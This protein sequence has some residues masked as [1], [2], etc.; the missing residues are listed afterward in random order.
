MSKH[1]LIFDCD[2]VIVDSEC[3]ATDVLLDGI[4][5]A[6]AKID[7]HTA[8][9]RFLGRSDETVLRILRDEFD[10]E[11]TGPEI[12]LMQERLNARLRSEL[13]PTAGVVDALNSIDQRVCVASSSQPERI[14]LSLSATGLLGYFEPHIFSASM[15]ANGKPAPDLFLHAAAAVVAAPEHCIVIEDSPAGIRAAQSAGMAVL[16]YHRGSHAALSNLETT[17]AVLQP[18][19]CFDDMRA[20]PDLIAEIDMRARNS[21]SA[22]TVSVKEIG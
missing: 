19:A 1:L 5:A 2:G 7:D 16:A 4:R 22:A 21:D 11:L 20:L 6:G 10:V 17:V 18:D 14:R 8:Y 15:V 9:T 13:C 12:A 3:L